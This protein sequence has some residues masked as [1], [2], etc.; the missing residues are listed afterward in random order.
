M[1]SYD[2]ANKFTKILLTFSCFETIFLFHRYIPIKHWNQIIADISVSENNWILRDLIK[3]LEIG[4][5]RLG[6]R[7]VKIFP[8]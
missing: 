5:I 2:F 6:S 3:N 1:Y 4:L 8:K 7:F